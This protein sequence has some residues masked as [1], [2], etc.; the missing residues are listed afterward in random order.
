MGEGVNDDTPQPGSAQPAH[1]TRERIL[2][3]AAQVFAEQ[4]YARATTRALAA[5][6]GVN[7]VTLFRH[8]GS[9]QA[10]FAAVIDRHAAPALTTAMEAQL[11]GDYRQDL[12]TFA[13]HLTRAVIER[14]ETVRLM[15]CEAAHFPELRD[16]L[17]QN[18]RQ[19]R[20]VLAGYL[21]EQM[22]RGRVRPL[23]PEVVAQA[24]W[25]MFFAYG[26]S[27]GLLDEP[28]DPELAIDELIAQFVDIFVAG[29]LLSE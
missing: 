12:M 29:T 16:I 22:A 10:L 15:L 14:R 21:K 6:A 5:A 7:E 4:G 24:F 17:V 28:V 18:P 1:D 23:H 2:D 8:F 9:K 19:L 20:R 27:V 13:T 11:T 25:G 26:I 3:S